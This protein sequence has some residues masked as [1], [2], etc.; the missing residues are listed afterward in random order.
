MNSPDSIDPRAQGFG[1]RT[2]ALA[3]TLSFA[4]LPL[5]AS[6]EEPA[7][8]NSQCREHS[9]AMLDAIAKADF[10][11]A[12]INFDDAMKTALPPLA[13]NQSWDALVAKY[14]Q[15]HQ[16]GP[17]RVGMAQGFTLVQTPLKFDHG[18]LTAQVACAT[19]GAISG[20]HV[21]PIDQIPDVAKPTDPSLPEQ[22]KF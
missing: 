3:L 2:L 8:P 13:L 14:G 10:A 1:Y 11:T 17:A 9:E 18:D 6:A 16:R 19:S 21:L 20:F 7:K 4:M 15:P 12:S 22:P 5:L